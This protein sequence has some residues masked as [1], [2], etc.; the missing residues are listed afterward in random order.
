MF[1]VFGCGNGKIDSRKQQTL[2]TEEKKAEAE[3][4]PVL[5]LKGVQDF[6]VVKDDKEVKKFSEIFTKPYFVLALFD[7]ECSD[8]VGIAEVNPYEDLQDG[9]KSETCDFGAVVS[10]NA[11]RKVPLIQSHEN[12]WGIHLSVKTIAKRFGQTFSNR[13]LVLLVDR[14]GK[15]VA[16]SKTTDLKD[17]ATI[18]HK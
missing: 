3:A 10:R 2:V 18:C 12:V 8:C 13:F 5:T 7:H 17:L 1:L 16:L 4:L 9:L 15:V 6:T 14:A 11:L